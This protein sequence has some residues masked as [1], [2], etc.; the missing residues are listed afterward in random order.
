MAA[1]CKLSAV[2]FAKRS[3]FVPNWRSSAFPGEGFESTALADVSAWQA[4]CSCLCPRRAGAKSAVPSRSRGAIPFLRRYQAVHP[5]PFSRNTYNRNSI[6]RREPTTA[7]TPR[8]AY[9]PRRAP[10]R[11]GA[12]SA[13]GEV[14]PPKHWRARTRSRAWG[15]DCHCRRYRRSVTRRVPFCG[16]AAVCRRAGHDGTEPGN[17]LD[18]RSFLLLL[19]RKACGT[20]WTGRQWHAENPQAPRGVRG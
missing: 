1:A 7:A 17:N 3:E 8:G 12:V 19:R 20:R 15:R 4:R 13:E 5:T 9:N 2:A 10:S 6:M 16:T 14:L 11:C 18:M